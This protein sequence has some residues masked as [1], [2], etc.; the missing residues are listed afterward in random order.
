MLNHTSPRT[1]GRTTLAAASVAAAVVVTLSG[2]S[3][4]AAAGH[5]ATLAVPIITTV[6]GGTGG[7]GPATKIALDYPC[8]VAFAAGSLDVGDGFAQQ[9]NPHTGRLTTVAG[10]VR[11]ISVPG[12]EQ[13]PLG[14][15]GPASH[16]VTA[17][18]GMT[19]DGAGNLVVADGVD[20][21]IR[22][23][24]ATS[25][26]FYGQKMTAHF[27]YTVAGSGG[28]GISGN[29]GPATKAKLAN[30]MDV[31]ADQAGNLVLTDSGSPSGKVPAQ[32]QVVAAR[33]G[34]FYGHTMIAGHIY[35]V[36]GN[37]QSSQVSGDGGPAANAGLG[38]EVGELNLDRAGNVVLA[39]T[40]GNSIRVV[41]VSN[42]TFYGQK[43]TAGDIYTVAGNGT[44]GF[45]GNGGPATRAEM[46]HPLGV[47]VDSSGNLVVA[48]TA[49][50]RVR[51]V[52]DSSGT[53]YGKRMAAH[54]IYN[55]A[56]CGRTSCAL[57]DG[58]P[59]TA[60]RLIVPDSVAVDGTG[61]LIVA[62]RG[63]GR[64]SKDRRV[65][66]VAAS[67]GTSYGQKMTAGDMYTVAGDGF[68]GYSGDR[69]PATR[70]V[71]MTT[72][73]RMVVDGAGNVVVAAGENNRL[74]VW[75]ATSG[76]FYGAKMTAHH[77]YT[78]AGGGAFPYGGDGG[79]ATKAGMDFP[80]G[81][82]I[83]QHGNLV[84]SDEGNN[85][86]RVV[87]DSSGT[88]Y[89]RKMKAHFI[90]TVAG[91]GKPGFSGDGGPATNAMLRVVSGVA[92]DHAG[93]LLIADDGNNRIRAVAERNG[94]FYGNTMTAGDIYTIAG[95]GTPGFSG[96]GGPATKAAL[97][98][99]RDLTVDGHGNVIIA[100]DGSNRVRVVAASG[101]TFY[102][103]TMT[104]GDIYTIAGNGTPGF[105]GDGGPAT[106]ARL[107]AP[108]GVALNSAGALFV[109][110]SYR[111]RMVSPGG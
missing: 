109:A 27:I 95:N 34:S 25:G 48:D 33:S 15:R 40:S 97:H 28:G 21:R 7:P 6:A 4:S 90:Y 86:V 99:P 83:D 70:A 88:F 63:A 8:G 104:A 91:D 75:P 52:A 68:R 102:G 94:T 92:V 78:V 54:D 50:N 105:S 31:Q 60:A 45:S 82:A 93:N 53:F 80:D 2:A 30:V 72:S 38:A 9:V 69:W 1:G 67:S 18:C 96:D 43:M 59:A 49:N 13:V 51:V 101:G 110:D 108:S 71:I 23:V 84:V 19:T 56:G 20:R 89:Q 16:A 100:D 66:L 36:A 29:G 87:T 41:A 73:S 44:A 37:P 85:R 22:V 3:S 57:G 47:A 39:D 24:A 5:S 77:I 11:R 35:R 81:L 79:P 42:G 32:V 17:A 26:T 64:R 10:G 12:G 111:V 107:V 74:R 55:V 58:G 103:Q 61:N 76:T 14:D 65:R 106:K 46:R 98:L 62:E